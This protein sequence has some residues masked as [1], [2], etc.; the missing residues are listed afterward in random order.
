MRPVLLEMDGFASYRQKTSMTFDG[1]DY[2]VLVGPTGA[3]K[4]TIIDAITFALYGCVV[5]WDDARAVEPALAPTVNRG[6]IKLVFDAGGD[7]YLATRILQRSSAGNVQQKTARLERLADPK[8]LGGVDD[9]ID[10]VAETIDG[11]RKAVEHLLGLD[12][13][14]FSKCV[15]LPQGQ[16]AELLHAKPKER[17]EIL[18]KLLGLDIY[19]RIG[20]VARERA[21]ILT[22]KADALQHQ[23]DDEK[24][25]TSDAALAAANLR[26][27]TLRALRLQIDDD[28]VRLTGLIESSTKARR[29][30]DDRAAEIKT[31]DRVEVPADISDLDDR[32]Q[33]ATADHIAA[34]ATANAAEQNDSEA[35]AAVSARPKRSELE[36]L[37]DLHN[38]RRTEVDRQPELT[39]QVAF[40]AEQAQQ[41]QEAVERARADLETARSA[42]VA[43][44]DAHTGA[45][46]A[47]TESTR[48]RDLLVAVR[49]P[50]GLDEITTKITQAQSAAAAAA[51]EADTAKEKRRTADAALA[52]HPAAVDLE[53]ASRS[54]G[55]ARTAVVQLRQAIAA[56]GPAHEKA[57]QDREAASIAAETLA[58]AQ[59]EADA[60]ASR[61]VAAEL[62]GHL[63]VGHECPVC[64]Q[65]VS[66]LPAPLKA[67]S[68]QAAKKQLTAAQKSAN[69]TGTAA[70]KSGTQL[71]SHRLAVI[72][73]AQTVGARIA[74]AADAVENVPGLTVIRAALATEP[75]E[76]V[77]V[78]TESTTLAEK[79]VGLVSQLE[80]ISAA[81]DAVA[82]RL[83]IAEFARNSADAEA[84]TAADAVTAAE[85]TVSHS[86]VA[87]EATSAQREKARQA[88]ST[89][90]DP[91]VALGAPALDDSDLAAAWYRLVAWA[92]NAAESQ[93]EV[94]ARE[95]GTVATLEAEHD[96]RTEARDQ[97]KQSA[98]DAEIA[99]AAAAQAQQHAVAAQ[100]QSERNLAKLNHELDGALSAEDV[101]EQLAELA[102][103][104]SAVRDAEDKLKLART[105]RASATAALESVQKEDRSARTALNTARDGLVAI[106]RPPATDDLGIAQAWSDLVGWAVATKAEV[107]ERRDQAAASADRYASETEQFAGSMRE[108]LDE[109]D[110]DASDSRSPHVWAAAEV[111]A[112]GASAAEA[113]KHIQQSRER[114]DSTIKE[115]ARAREHSGVADELG[116]L[117]AIN[118]FPRWLNRNALEVLTTSASDT[119]MELSGGQFELSLSDGESANF[120]VIDHADADAVRPVKTLSGG[121]TFQASLALALALAQNLGALANNGAAQ[122]DALFI[123]EG[124]GTLDEPTLDVVANTL[125]ALALNA[126]RMVGVITHVPALAARVPVRFRVDR[127]PRGSTVNRESV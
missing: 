35:R 109:A 77:D 36:R 41:A 120:T 108:R 127:D 79:C 2:F 92:V 86:R 23:L 52:E 59:T 125:E 111:A 81:L 68:A 63:E 31:L 44:A 71:E 107:G 126:G 121:E 28:V 34:D 97:A 11:T 122:L 55:E 57:Q 73:A 51:A 114:R 25:D 61:E 94:V 118:G 49:A 15:A 75:I 90:R 104:E 106:G 113:V 69:T 32:M 117:L 100:E 60:F 88:L 96:Q 70:T 123:D 62:R 21:K 82:A 78:G 27:V 3:G 20:Q 30:R 80:T 83:D 124:F 42:E 116:R 54:V 33:R 29:E 102:V 46:Q 72:T 14:Q 93:A 103:L 105:R 17:D 95:A 40:T 89:T 45:A 8:A 76:S 5:R 4:S 12:F 56:L 67:S 110:I 26:V 84:R 53:R 65:K 10:V 58:A 98:S 64:E 13:N 101:A 66:T 47:L 87:I 91:L 7:R 1:V 9:D 119:L 43:A 37:R 50:T 19:L 48:R 112:A 74:A 24:V 18:T 22:T 16:F 39:E 6:S 115:I 85:E 38:E 99:Q